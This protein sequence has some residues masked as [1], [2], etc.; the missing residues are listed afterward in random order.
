MGSF[1]GLVEIRDRFAVAGY[2]WYFGFYGQ[3]FGGDLV[4]HGA[5][6]LGRRT[7][8]DQ[9]CSYDFFGK[10][11]IFG[12][13]PVSRMD[14]LAAGRLR[15]RDRA[16]LRITLQT[17]LPARLDGGRGPQL[18]DG[19]ALGLDRLELLP[20]RGHLSHGAAIDQVDLAGLEREV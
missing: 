15:G 18:V 10:I 20:G 12:Q 13:E 5:D 16:R 9:A 17:I 6:D 19:H 2:R 3:L 1:T 11:R 14:R 4:T 7:D 8:K